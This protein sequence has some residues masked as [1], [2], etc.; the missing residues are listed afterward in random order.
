MRALFHPELNFENDNAVIGPPQTHHLFN[1]VRIKPGEQLLILDGRGGMLLSEVIQCSKKEIA[2]K[3]LKEAKKEDQRKVDL[4]LAPPKK[5]TF[6][7][8]LRS[9]VELDIRHINLVDTEYSNRFSINE[10]KVEKILIGSY[11]Q[12]N[13]PFTVAVSSYDSL[14]NNKEI[15]NRYNH[16]LY[17]STMGDILEETAMNRQLDQQDEILVVI[18]PEGGFSPG[19]HEFFLSLENVYEIKLKTNILRSQTAVSAALGY[20]HGK[21]L[22]P[23]S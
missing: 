22:L 5:D 12:S 15:F 23:C 2:I 21:L 9:A 17:F 6:H 18:G 14:I 19:E 16:V 3:K 7:E 8:I 1:V 13:S 11:E 20:I 4:L 10:E